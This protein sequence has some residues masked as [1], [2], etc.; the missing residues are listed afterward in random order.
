MEISLVQ[1]SFRWESTYLKIKNSYFDDNFKINQDF[2]F[3]KSNQSDSF[4]V[5]MR[6]ETNNSLKKWQLPDTGWCYMSHD[7][8]MPK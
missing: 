4:L 6:I 5:L 2:E 1:S 3:E 8:Y 7:A